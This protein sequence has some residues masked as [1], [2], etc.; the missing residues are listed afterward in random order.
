[1]ADNANPTRFGRWLD[2]AQQKITDSLAEQAW[3]QELKGKWDELEPRN[4]QIILYG[5]GATAVAL[6]IVSVLAFVYGAYSLKSEYA[7]K[8]ELLSVIQGATQ[9]VRFL[10]QRLGAGASAEEPGS[11]DKPDWRSIFMGTAA[12]SNILEP[13]V[14]ISAEKPGESNGVTSESLFEISI[15]R[16]NI[17]QAVRF[18]H[19]LENSPNPVKIRNL[20]VETEGAEGYLNAKYFVSAFALN[21]KK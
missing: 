2:E 12:Q 10:K 4:R 15:K 9:E 3:F 5:G 16:V 18:A 17:K 20:M 14:Q 1:M 7:K 8:V 6:C 13:S 21:S 19:A 11:A